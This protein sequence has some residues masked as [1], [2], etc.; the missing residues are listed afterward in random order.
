MYCADHKLNNMID[1]INEKCEFNN[2]TIRACFNYENEKKGKYCSEH[3]LIN[4]VN[5]KDINRI[6]KFNNCFVR[7]SF[8]YPNENN[9]LFCVTHK[10]DGMI[11]VV[12][13]LCMHKN[14]I[15]RP[16]FNYHDKEIGIYCSNHKLD[17]MIDV[18]ANYCIYND[19]QIQASFCNP[20]ETKPIYCV[21]HKLDNMI[22]IKI[23]KCIHENCNLAASFNYEGKTNRLFCSN[24]K[25][26]GMIN[27]C[28]NFCHSPLCYTEG[29]DKYN[30]YCARCYVHMNPDNPISRNYKTKESS[31][32]LFIK[33]HFPS[34]N[35]IIDKKI[36]N[37]SSNRRPDILIEL[38]HQNIIIE[39]D[40]NQ[41]K[42]YDCS[43]DNKRLMEL[44]KDLNHKNIVFIRFN[45]DDYVNCKG[46]KF[47]SCWIQDKNGKLKI[48][49]DKDWDNRLN[50]LKNQINYWINPKNKTNKMIEII[51]LYFDEKVVI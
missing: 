24:H 35:L 21:N 48:K 12:N 14:C 2:C 43:C 34:L 17:G 4:M 25:K 13:T 38:D 20:N 47:K 1:V 26:E 42:D 29:I 27:I 32:I 22:N 28:T 16:R 6:C 10:L 23:K 37:G 33:K 50:N 46:T 5:I 41:H 3:K 30:G 40:E 19:C 51:Q 49:D 7:P 9:P 8:N 15:I 31:V 18:K 36:S 11:N 44:S 45:P 39:I